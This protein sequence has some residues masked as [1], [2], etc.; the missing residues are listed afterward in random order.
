MEKNNKNSNQESFSKV[1]INWYPGH[2]AKT[3]RE[4]AEKINLIDVIYE[5]IDSRMPLSSKIIDIDNLIKNKPRIIVFT[6]YDLCD[7]E[8]TNK[9]VSYYESLGHKVICCDLINNQNVVN[10]IIAESNVIMKEMNEK[11]KAKGMKPRSIRALV[12]GVP[13]AGKS[14]LIN[15]LVGKKAA[16]IGDKPGVTKSLSWI[17]INKDIELLDSPGILWP[18]IENQNHAYNLAALSSIKEE[19]LD[20]YLLSIHI[21]KTMY[22][23]Y[24]NNLKERYGI[25]SID[26]EDITPTLDQIAVKRGALLKGGEKDYDKVYSIII[27]DLKENHLGKITF[28]RI[29]ELQETN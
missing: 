21:L 25:E 23:L 11:R 9:F 14:T 13:N 27:R 22:R 12:V 3:K 28:D 4:I 24:P 15:R 5:V 8:E 10:K 18:K 29:E 26:F 17:R 2:M 20:P 19:I 1:S 6:K 16:V 7:Q